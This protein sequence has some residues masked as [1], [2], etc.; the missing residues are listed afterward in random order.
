[1]LSLPYALLGL[2]NPGILL[3]GSLLMTPVP[4]VSQLPSGGSPELRG[5]TYSVLG[6]ASILREI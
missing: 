4:T 6:R 5:Q 3:V 2:Y 1:M